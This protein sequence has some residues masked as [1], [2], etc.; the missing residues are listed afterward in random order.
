MYT[1]NYWNYKGENAVSI[2]ARCPDWY[3][4]RQYK[5]LAPK[6][7]FWKKHKETQDHD[8]YRKYYYLEVLKPLNP[9]QVYE[10]LGE[11]AV[12]LCWELPGEFCHRRLVAK[13]ME[14][15]LG[16]LVPEL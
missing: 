14:H 13:W 2:A 7:W 1:S 12:L 15:E 11:N 8:F 6:Y 16:V 5:K 4:G 9:Q 10:E 3:T